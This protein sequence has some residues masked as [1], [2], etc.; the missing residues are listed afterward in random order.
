[1]S[2]VGEDIKYGTDI[3]QWDLGGDYS[4]YEGATA[5]AASANTGNIFD[6]ALLNPYLE[7]LTVDK[8]DLSDPWRTGYLT[9]FT[10]PCMQ[11]A[12]NSSTPVTCAAMCTDAESLFSTWQTLWTC[13]QLASISLAAARFKGID[14]EDKLNGTI[15][16]ALKAV[17]GPGVDLTAINGAAV[18]NTTY[19][20]AL[21]SC[22]QNSMGRCNEDL[23]DLAEE[24]L[25][26]D[27]N[28]WS[29]LNDTY[30]NF[31]ESS[32]N[33]DVAGPG[34]S[35]PRPLFAASIWDSDLTFL[36]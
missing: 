25:A 1:M 10:H 23:E 17:S 34:V 33:V 5:F 24:F 20:C 31:V 11:V 21:A 3:L 16:A 36:I 26:E 18:L 8:E 32:I 35:H 4:L 14:G 19:R 27:S 22:T 15:K 2:F 29:F 28:Q 6:E 12:D 7:F 13:L 30:C 9:L